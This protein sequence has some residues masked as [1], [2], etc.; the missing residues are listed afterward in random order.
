LADPRLDSENKLES[1][2][3]KLPKEFGSLIIIPGSDQELKRELEGRGF[4]AQDSSPTLVLMSFWGKVYWGRED[5]PR[6]AARPI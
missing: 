4:W 1:D 6:F 5:D 2:L 3:D